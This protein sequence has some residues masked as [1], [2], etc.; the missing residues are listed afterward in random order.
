MRVYFYDHK[1]VTVVLVIVELFVYSFRWPVSVA[2]ARDPAEYRRHRRQYGVTPVP[3]Q[4][5]CVITLI[6]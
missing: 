4:F 2:D 3:V 1:A 6:G 5:S